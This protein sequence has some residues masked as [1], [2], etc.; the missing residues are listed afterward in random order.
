MDRH[1]NY[2]WYTINNIAGAATGAEKSFGRAITGN[3]TYTTYKITGFLGNVSIFSTNPDGSQA[4]LYAAYYN[5]S[6]N[7]TA[8]AFYSG[9]PSPPDNTF[10]EAAVEGLGNCIPNVSLS[11]SN[12]TDFDSIEW[13]YWNGSGVVTYTNIPGWSTATVTPTNVGFYKAIGI[14]NCGTKN[15]RLESNPKKVSN[16]PLDLDGDGIINNIDVDIDNDGIYN[17]VES[18][19]I[20]NFDLSDINNPI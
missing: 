4:E 12:D 5:T 18:R 15:F 10:N 6:S 20:N 7:A 19:A 9:F 16:C 1:C 3:T 13:E 17:T 2:W 11:I 14:I 8:G